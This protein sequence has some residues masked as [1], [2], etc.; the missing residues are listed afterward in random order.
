MTHTY[1]Y[2]V[3]LRANPIG[4]SDKQYCDI[5]RKLIRGDKTLLDYDQ[6]LLRH[7]CSNELKQISVGLVKN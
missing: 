4:V 2:S 6:C 7:A 1:M 5:T 3:L